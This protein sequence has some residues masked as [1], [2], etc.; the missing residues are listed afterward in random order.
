MITSLDKVIV[1]AAYTTNDD[2]GSR[3]SCIGYTKTMSAALELAKDRGFYGG[4]GTVE[5]VSA[6]CVVDDDKQS[7]QYWLLAST[8]P[9]DIDQML[10]KRDASLREETLSSLTTEQKRVLGLTT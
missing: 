5:T 9:I 6:L 1:Y 7:D 3:G 8:E 10:Q 4:N 2:R